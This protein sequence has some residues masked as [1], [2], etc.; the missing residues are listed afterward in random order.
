MNKEVDYIIVGQ[1]IAG[2]V[3]AQSLIQTGKKVIV[4]DKG[5]EQSASRVAPG[6]FNP[7]SFKRISISWQADKLIPFLIHFYKSLETTLSTPLLHLTDIFKIISSEEELGKWRKKLLQED[8][9]SFCSLQPNYN[10]QIN[11]PCGLIKVSPAGYLDVKKMLSEFRK[12]LKTNNQLQEEDFDCSGIQFDPEHIIY[13]NCTAKKIIFC[14]GKNSKANSFFNWL[15]IIPNQGELLTIKTDQLKIN[16]IYA[17]KAFILPAENQIKLGATYNWK[18]ATNL[19]TE[20]AKSELCSKLEE[21][22]ATAYKVVEHLVGIRPTVPDRRPLIGI[23]PEYKQ[24]AVF[25][26]LGSKGVMLAPYF[27]DQLMQ[28]IENK[29]VLDKEVDILRYYN[30]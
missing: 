23:H 4:I 10:K 20:E 30:K 2:T 14:E 29:V 5:H 27:A 16:H 19:P 9:Q 13:K 25:N 28:N 18:E 6:L 15:P 11:A 24:L 26:G 8:I 17:K 7:I 1:G 3:L 12:H 22:T 21:M